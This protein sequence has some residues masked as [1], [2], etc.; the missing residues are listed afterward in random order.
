MAVLN[1]SADL[2]FLGGLLNPSLH[3][4]QFDNLLDY[5]PDERHAF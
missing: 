1:L 5:G 4:A 2:V 3:I